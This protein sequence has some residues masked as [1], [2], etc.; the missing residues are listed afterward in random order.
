[1]GPEDQD[2]L[3]SSAETIE[4]VFYSRPDLKD[5]ALDN[6][7]VEWFSDR[8]HSI[9]WGRRRAGYAN[10]SLQETKEAK[11]LPWEPWPKMLNS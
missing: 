7:D 11:P 9:D 10:M 8:S 5:I 4:Q 6:P 1:M 2:I 3:H